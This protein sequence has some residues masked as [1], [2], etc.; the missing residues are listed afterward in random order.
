MP[1]RQQK[2]QWNQFLLMVSQIS[3]LDVIFQIQSC[4]P[5]C[6][7]CSTNLSVNIPFSLPQ[8]SSPAVLYPSSSRVVRRRD[9][10]DFISLKNEYILKS[11][12]KALKC[13]ERRGKEEKTVLFNG[14]SREP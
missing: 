2:E 7:S 11:G 8:Q 3:R 10:N 4:L 6:F 12:H 13:F 9:S 14:F 5:I 1:P